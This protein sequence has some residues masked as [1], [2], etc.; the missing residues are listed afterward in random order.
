MQ[1]SFEMDLLVKGKSF[2]EDIS[3]LS[4]AIEI[5]KGYEESYNVCVQFGAKHFSTDDEEIISPKIGLVSSKT[6]SLE[7]KTALDLTVE[8]GTAIAPLLPPMV[9]YSIELYKK[10]SDLVAIATNFFN[11]TG[12]QPLTVNITDSPGALV[13]VNA[14]NGKINVSPDVYNAAV[15]MHKPLNRMAEQIDA[16]AADSIEISTPATNT[17]ERQVALRIDETNKS[18]FNLPSKKVVSD[19]VVTLRCGIYRFNKKTGVG[20]LDVLEEGSRKSINFE[21]VE[22]DYEKFIEA[23]SAVYSKISA[24]REMYVNALGEELIKKLHIHAI[25]NFWDDDREREAEAVRVRG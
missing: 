3:T 15:K 6:G 14:G 9:A 4:L 13:L 18:F 2:T 8:L 23:L 25:E 12:G 7:V 22:V 5:L 11:K 10:S 24:T 21:V 19:Q 1:E 20:G 17:Q 16:R